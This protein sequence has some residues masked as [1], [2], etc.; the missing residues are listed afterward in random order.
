[1][2]SQLSLRK[3]ELTRFATSSLSPACRRQPTLSTPSSGGHAPER[4]LFFV[5]TSNAAFVSWD[6]AP[7]PQ[8][9]VLIQRKLMPSSIRWCLGNCPNS[10]RKQG[11]FT[12]WWLHHTASPLSHLNTLLLPGDSSWPQSHCQRC[13][14]TLQAE[15]L[16]KATLS[17][18]PA[19]PL[20]PC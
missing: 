12:V 14:S 8:E 10:P 9:E 13:G 19:W 18:Q 16:V 3:L 17:L 11:T 2:G 20:G 15:T 7:E 5:A 4:P 1:M 6:V